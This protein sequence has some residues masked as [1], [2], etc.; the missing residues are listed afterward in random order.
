MRRIE[1]DI[2]IFGAGIMG[3]ATAYALAKDGHRVLLVDRALPNAGSSGA[4]DGYVSVSTKTPGPTLAMA[5]ASQLLYPAL[6]QE[7]GAARID[8]RRCGGL[9]LVETPDEHDK[10]AAHAA[11]LQEAGVAARLIDR[12]QMRRIEPNLSP[13]LHGAIDAPDEAQVTPYLA[14]LALVAAAREIGARTLWHARPL[15]FDIAGDIVRSATLEDGDG[16]RVALAAEQFVLCAGIGS[17]DLG[18]LVG[19]DLPV[20]PRRGELLVTARGRPLASRFLVSARYL[21]AKLDPEAAKNSAD[22][23]VR[24]G[25]GF[26]LEATPHGQHIVG[27]TRVFA[28]FE[29][30]VSADGYKT[31]LAE[32]AK[33]VPALA[34]ATVLR[35]FAGLRPFVPDKRPLIGRSTIRA[36]VLVAAG[37]EGDGITLA[38]L[39]AD[40]VA[41]LARGRASPFPLDG[42]APDRFSRSLAETVPARDNGAL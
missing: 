42:L 24:M 16:D 1:T 32:G 7:L 40:I 4:C 39:T 38:P 35:A 26:T 6:A 27:N 19:L 17:R 29:R 23:L 5:R 37:H 14:T 9:M 3:A 22:P 20:V 11:L 36:N 10:M 25:Y 2:A 15:A 28:G 21:T 31:I 30:G 18:A 12:A 8:Y 33:R 13:D 41:A 34:K